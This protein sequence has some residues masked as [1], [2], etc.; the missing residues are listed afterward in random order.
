M[1]VACVLSSPVF[2]PSFLI[3]RFGFTR[4]LGSG[5][6][7][8]FSFFFLCLHSSFSL[9]SFLRSPQLS[10]GVVFD[11]VKT[12]PVVVT[13]KLLVSFFFSSF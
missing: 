5:F 6:T 8:L 7:K 4:I 12:K 1:Y 2:P 10:T 9:L 13:L 11:L 3:L